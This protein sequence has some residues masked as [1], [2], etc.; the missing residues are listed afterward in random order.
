MAINVE[1]DFH[2]IIENFSH[3]YNA[4]SFPRYEPMEELSIFHF[5]LQGPGSNYPRTSPQ[6]NAFSQTH[7]K[8]AIQRVA[9]FKSGTLGVGFAALNISE[10]CLQSTAWRHGGMGEMIITNT[11]ACPSCVKNDV[12]EQPSLFYTSW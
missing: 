2:A 3:V 11:D 1:T 8:N 12:E 5:L 9:L 7:Q 10:K 4:G 6:T